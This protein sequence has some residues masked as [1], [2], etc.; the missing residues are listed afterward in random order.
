MCVSYVLPYGGWVWPDSALDAV[1]AHVHNNT[2]VMAE[3]L[4]Y[5]APDGS[6]VV[7]CIL[8]DP[9][10]PG[11]QINDGHISKQHGQ[12]ATQRQA[13]PTPTPLAAHSLTYPACPCVRVCACAQ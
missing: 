5:L 10:A 12:R 1:Q 2:A 13:M 8:G 9:T 11:P 7:V 6:H 3:G 4:D